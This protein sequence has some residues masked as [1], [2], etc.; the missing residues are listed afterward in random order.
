MKKLILTMLA[1]AATLAAVPALADNGHHRGWNKHH[2]KQE[3]HHGHHDRHYGRH[4][5]RHYTPRHVVVVP[6]PVYH[7]APPP[8]VVYAPPPAVVHPAPVYYPA[9]V[10]R[11]AEPSVSFR[12]N[13]PL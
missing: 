9:P 10:Y 4:Y 7:Y 2:W 1:G 13:V 12:I 11:H 6:A 5:E 3:R 8:H